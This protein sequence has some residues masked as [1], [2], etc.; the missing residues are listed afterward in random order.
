MDIWNGVG[1]GEDDAMNLKPVRQGALQF[2]QKDA[3][4]A[5]YAFVPRLP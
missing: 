4:S 5:G 1:V 2:R 3:V